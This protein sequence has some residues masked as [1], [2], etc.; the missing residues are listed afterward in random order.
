MFAII[1][2][3]TTGGSAARDKITE[4]A[5]I[6]HDGTRRVDEYQTLVNPERPIPGY[7]TD[8]TGISDDMV[9]DAPRF[10]EVAADVVRFTENCI[11]VAHNVNFDYSF[12]REEFG[13]LGYRYERERL[14]TVRLSRKLMPG[15]RS[16]SLGKIC[17]RLGIA[18]H[19]RHRAMGD[20][21]ATVHL[22]EH[23]IGLDPELPARYATVADPFAGLPEQLDRDRLAEVPEKAGMFFFHDQAGQVLYADKTRNIRQ[24]A[25]KQLRALVEG[26]AKGKVKALVPEQVHEVSFELTGNELLAS[27]RLPEELAR[28]GPAKVA[29]SSARKYKAGIYLYHDQRNYLRLTIGKLTKGQ[30]AVVEFPTEE[31]ARIAL[32]ARMKA[33]GLCATLMGLESGNGPCTYVTVGTCRGACTGAESA[34]EYNAR[35]EAALEGLGFPH[36]RFLLLGNG[37]TSEEVSVICVEGGNCL[38]Y[39]YLDASE[40]WSDPGAVRELLNPFSQLAEAGRTVR[41]YISRVQSWQIIPY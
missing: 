23:L 34:A 13:R 30:R 14:C 8:I 41:Q 4:I 32:R 25:F 35:L 6:L 27:L 28:R 24:T 18:N 19:A 29:G 20:A 5:I 40:S 39:A 26:T 33:H 36:P 31:A 3:E 37:R 38:G 16:Y 10:H 22:L 21:D 12:L 15:A 9:A 1:D 11:F 7:I 17:A 2:L